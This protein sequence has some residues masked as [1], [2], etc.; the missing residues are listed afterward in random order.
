MYTYRELVD[1]IEEMT[2][3]DDEKLAKLN[4]RPITKAVSTPSKQS[5]D[6]EEA[7]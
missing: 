1:R 5:T 6:A 7:G 4:V 2:M 3:T